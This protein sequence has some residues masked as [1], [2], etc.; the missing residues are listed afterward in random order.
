MSLKYLIAAAITSALPA[1]LINGLLP[2]ARRRESVERKATEFDDQRIRA[3]QEKRARK[4]ERR[5]A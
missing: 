1:P 2:A 4:A 5:K 3:A